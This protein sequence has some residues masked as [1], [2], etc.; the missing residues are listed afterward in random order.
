MNFTKMQGAG[1]DYIYI[2]CTSTPAPDGL[3]DLAVRMSDRHFGVGGDGIVLILPSSVADF[4]MRMFNAD[5]SE[6]QMCGNASR[7]IGKYVYDN[8]L[9]DGR[10]TVTL[11]TLGGIKTLEIHPG[12]DGKVES[13]TVDMG[14]PILD[15]NRIPVISRG[16]PTFIDTPMAT[17]RGPVNVTAVSMGNPH[18][19]VF[20]DEPLSDNL[21]HGLGREMETLPAWPEKANIEFA[22]II[23]PADIEMRVWERGSGETLACGTGA[24]ATAVAAAL[25]GRASRQAR[26]HLLGGTLSIDWRDDNG[27]VMMTG[28]AETVFSGTYIRK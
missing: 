4:R 21:I 15:C 26:I 19:V 1:N 7:C 27:H 2:D 24:C 20:T 22:R 12:A 10:T 18:G 11:E 28:P 9:S 17:S 6:A 8:G 14:A 25:T 13:V 16:A 23:G 3:A 5:G